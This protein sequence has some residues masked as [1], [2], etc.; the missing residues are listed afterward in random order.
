MET[1]HAQ[2]LAPQSAEMQPIIAIPIPETH[3]SPSDL[4]ALVPLQDQHHVAPATEVTEPTSSIVTRSSFS[5]SQVQNCSTEEDSRFLAS[6]TCVSPSTSV[7]SSLKKNVCERLPSFEGSL[8]LGNTLCLPGSYEH[9]QMYESSSHPLS[10]LEESVPAPVPTPAP[11]LGSLSVRIVTLDHYTAAP[12]EGLDPMCST[13]R[14]TP[15][16]RVPVIRIF[17]ATPKGWFTPPYIMFQ[18]A[19]VFQSVDINTDC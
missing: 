6:F 18:N 12:V 9:L 15:V 11:M 8:H 10:P 16:S 2:Q 7:P 17:G 14:G 5:S 1:S 3:T 13:F 4:D 19:Y